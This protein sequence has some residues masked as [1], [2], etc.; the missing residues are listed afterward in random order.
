LP[1]GSVHIITH[2]AKIL[3]T[4]PPTKFG[5]FMTDELPVSEGLA[6]EFVAEAACLLLSPVLVAD[7]IESSVADASEP[8]RY[9]E[10]ALS[11]IEL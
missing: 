9:F 11:I 2:K 7:G 8:C 6:S 4:T 1:A 5:I 3:P 10:L